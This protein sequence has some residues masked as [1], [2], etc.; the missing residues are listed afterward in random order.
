MIS[1]ALPPLTEADR[2]LVPRLATVCAHLDT[3]RVLRAVY[4]TPAV[5]R[6]LAGPCPHAGARMAYVSGLVIA[7]VAIVRRRQS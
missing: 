6:E 2:A 5:R 4:A 7:E 3:Q 1:L